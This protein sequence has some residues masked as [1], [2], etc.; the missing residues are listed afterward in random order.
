MSFKSKDI[1]GGGNRQSHDKKNSDGGDGDGDSDESN[2]ILNNLDN[3][4]TT[5][6]DMKFE[7]FINQDKLLSPNIKLFNKEELYDG[8]SKKNDRHNEDSI[9]DYFKDNNKDDHHTK[10]PNHS[11]FGPSYGDG[12]NDDGDRDNDKDKDRDRDND[13]ASETKEEVILKKL[14]MLRKLGEL[15]KYGVKLSQNYNMNS[16]YNAMKYEYELHKS[17][18][19]KQN[20]V[21][22]L[23]GAM[24]YACK[25]IELANDKLNPFDFKLKGW[26]DYVADDIGKY[27]EVLG[28]LHELYF[29]SGKSMHPA[30]KLMFMLSWSGLQFHLAQAYVGN[31]M[32]NLSNI[33]NNNP[34]LA[35]KLMQQAKADK[36]RGQSAN[37]RK[38]F[39]Q[40][41][42][43][44]HDVARQKATDI[45]MVKEKEE[46]FMRMQQQQQYNQPNQ[47]AQQYQQNIHI[48][49]KQQEQM[50]QQQMQ[51]QELQNQLNASRSDTR[52]MYSNVPVM[53]PS[54]QVPQNFPTP[55]SSN[56]PRAEQLTQNQL[57]LIRQ[58]QIMEQKKVLQE[59]DM[60]RRL[61]TK[62]SISINPQLEELMK[63]DGGGSMS[64]ILDEISV[65]DHSDTENTSKLIKRKKKKRKSTIKVDTS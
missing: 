40:A 26:G 24:I 14:D 32:P 47:Q 10:T 12:N 44:E 28:D 41:V 20:G 22:W 4:K 2:D 63:T 13:D 21:E 23:S 35:D 50:L 15:T 52:S 31:N 9:D 1:F 17:I 46:E 59:Q 25:G 16:D 65:V 5:E 56:M 8:D 29:K 11:K 42:N 37:Q 19:D 53:N 48:M 34:E 39:G 49:Q 30:L 55:M 43:K 51:I 38:M 6:T 45:Q 3:L 33:M 60:I 61:S 64:S 36:L 54:L 62:H 7:Y 58:Q 18:R 27:Y 57:D